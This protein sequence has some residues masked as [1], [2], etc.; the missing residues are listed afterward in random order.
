MSDDSEESPTGGS[1]RGGANAALGA[2]LATFDD[3]RLGRAILMPRAAPHPPGVQRPN[4]R[5]SDML[6][7]VSM[8]SMLGGN[9]V[10]VMRTYRPLTCAGK[11]A[12]W[13]FAVL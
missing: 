8:G 9:D 12:I 11:V 2:Q 4:T 10:T 1:G 3:T 5:T 7:Q 13:V 6:A